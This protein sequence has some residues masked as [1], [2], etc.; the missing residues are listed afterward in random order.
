MPRQN[1]GLLLL[2]HSDFAISATATA[3]QHTHPHPSFSP[4]S[5]HIVYTSD[6]TGHAQIYEAEIPNELIERLQ[7]GTN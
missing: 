3:P 1:A 7:N 5:R 4:D 2:F 6:R